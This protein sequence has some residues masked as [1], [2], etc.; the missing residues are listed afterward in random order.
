MD[1]APWRLRV[2]F[3]S[4]HDVEALAQR[5]RTSPAVVEN[6]ASV[7]TTTRDV[8]AY[9]ATLEAVESV[10]RAA[11]QAIEALGVK[12][13]LIR[14]DEWLPADSCWSGEP[15]LSKP[16]SSDGVVSGLIDGLLNNAWPW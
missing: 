8:F 15:P 5:L 10:K 11:W 9:A 16:Q 7:T 12:P 1:Q 14:I 6:G 13:T 2:S 4:Q 3:G